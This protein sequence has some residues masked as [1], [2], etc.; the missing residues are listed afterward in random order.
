MTEHKSPTRADYMSDRCTFEEYHRAVNATAGYR[1]TGDL[2]RVRAALAR[3]DYHLNS[4]PLPEWDATAIS[5]RVVHAPALRQHGDGW[6]L[7]G[8]VCCVKQA[9]RDAAQKEDSK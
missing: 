1:F 4:I 9:A 8:G 3:G 6:S 5:A 7:G 2:E